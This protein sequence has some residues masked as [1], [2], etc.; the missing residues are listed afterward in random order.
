LIHPLPFQ[1]DHA[2][3]T[4]D[5]HVARLAAAGGIPAAYIEPLKEGHEVKLNANEEVSHDYSGNVRGRIL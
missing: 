4:Q 3:S 1:D 5:T 2:R